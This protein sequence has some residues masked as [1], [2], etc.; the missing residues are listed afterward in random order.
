MSVCTAKVENPNNKS[1]RQTGQDITSVITLHQGADLPSFHHFCSWKR[2]LDCQNIYKVHFDFLIH[3]ILKY[4]ILC[5]SVNL[6][7]KTAGKLP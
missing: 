1:L 5:K 2:K 7:F 3:V 4:F 6:I